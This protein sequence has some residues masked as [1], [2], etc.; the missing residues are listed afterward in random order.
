MR[1][2]FIKFFKLDMQVEAYAKAWESWIQWYTKNSNG[3]TLSIA[4]YDCTI[5]SLLAFLRD[6][7]YFVRIR[8]MS[9]PGNIYRGTVEGRKGS[10]IMSRTFDSS[11]SYEKIES[12]LIKWALG[13]VNKDL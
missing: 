6:C 3:F 13:D 9:S 12:T 11:W 8:P 5:G 10:F 7:G 1:H 2:K 4:D